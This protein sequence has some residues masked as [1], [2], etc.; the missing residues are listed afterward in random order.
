[1]LGRLDYSL[2][3]LDPSHCLHF[4][5]WASHEEILPFVLHPE[6]TGSATL[7]NVG[8]YKPRDIVISQNTTYLETSVTISHV[9]RKTSEALKIQQHH[10]ENFTLCKR[11]MCLNIINVFCRL[12][13]KSKVRNKIHIDAIVKVSVVDWNHIMGHKLFWVI[14]I[15]RCSYGQRLRVTISTVS[16]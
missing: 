12:K 4:Q 8:N 15:L 3:R 13:P 10:C 11:K 5:R 9:H 16:T 6:D 1:V 7:W 14:T 2:R